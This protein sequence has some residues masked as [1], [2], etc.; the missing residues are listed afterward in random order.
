[1]DNLIARVGRSHR[2]HTLWYQW[3]VTGIFHDKLDDEVKVFVV[4]KA[5]PEITENEPIT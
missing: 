4:R 1:M 2:R 3:L 5:D